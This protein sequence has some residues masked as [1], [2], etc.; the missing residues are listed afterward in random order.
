MPY[1]RVLH[2]TTYRYRNPVSFGP[3]RLMIRPRDS[4]DLRLRSTRLAI[5]PKPVGIRWVYDVFG[6]SIAIARFDPADRSDRLVFES[7]LDLV[8]YVDALPEYPIEDYARTYPFAYTMEEAP[9][10]GRSI[11]RHYPIRSARS[12]A[13]PRASSAS[14]RRLIP[15]TCWSG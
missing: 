3:H 1:L 7:E 8:H 5:R 10:L 13:G 6:N 4:H 12:T 9:D 15:S 11:E 14:T 2:R